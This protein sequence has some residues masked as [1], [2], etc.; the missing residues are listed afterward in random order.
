MLSLWR[1]FNGQNIERHPQEPPVKHLKQKCTCNVLCTNVICIPSMYPRTPS[2][3]LWWQREPQRAERSVNSQPSRCCQPVEGITPEARPKQRTGNHRQHQPAGGAAEAV[4]LPQRPRSK[5]GGGKG[6]LLPVMIKHIYLFIYLER[7]QYIFFL[8]W[9]GVF[10]MKL[11]KL[12]F[13]PFF[14][15]GFFSSQFKIFINYQ[16]TA[17]AC[18][19]VSAFCV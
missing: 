17:K 8:L 2:L 12:S 15:N 18:S 16:H 7:V 4:T 14:P 19:P 1:C 9:C 5:Q 10:C 11:F 13:A 3:H 6:R